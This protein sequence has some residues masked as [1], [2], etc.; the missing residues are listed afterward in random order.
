V[1]PGTPSPRRRLDAVRALT[2][3]GFDVTVLMAP[4][5]PG[6]TD[7][8]A[9]ID[10]TVAAIAA[11][12]ATGVTPLPLHLR[13]GAREWYAAWLGRHHPAL[14]PR[15]R[16]LYGRGSYAPQTYQREVSARVRMA[17]RRHGLGERTANAA[18]E[19]AGSSTSEPEQTTQLTLL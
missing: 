13:P 2:E 5:L 6:L 10:A 15:Y 8:D 11:A 18:R 4:I 16:E 3:A 12:G 7:D 17:A 9:H 1:E 19:V 14:V